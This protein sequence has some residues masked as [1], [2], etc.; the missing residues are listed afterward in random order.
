[1]SF[2]LQFRKEVAQDIAEA[3]R[4]YKGQ[5]GTA[6]SNR[7]A[8]ELKATLARIASTPESYAKGE[9]GVRAAMLRV[10]PYIV[11]FRLTEKSV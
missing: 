9:R 6:L 4:W 3:R 1:M 7:F 10:F 5:G 8:R 2:R 11:Y